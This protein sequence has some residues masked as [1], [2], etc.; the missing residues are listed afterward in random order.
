M[1]NTIKVLQMKTEEDAEVLH[2]ENRL[3][4]L[5]SLVG[6]YIEDM[7]IGNGIVMLFNEE[8]NDKRNLALSSK[9]RITGYISGD[10]LFAGVESDE[11]V[12]L[13]DE[14]IALIESKYTGNLE[15]IGNTIKVFILN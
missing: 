3:E 12:S 14:Q 15:A 13:T 1:S 8:R 11:F 6:G 7:S 9:G 10:V 5:Q 4:V 2:V